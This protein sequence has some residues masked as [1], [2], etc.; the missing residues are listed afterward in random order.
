MPKKFELKE[1]STAHLEAHFNA[2]KAL[3]LVYEEKSTHWLMRANDCDE[4]ITR[5]QTEITRRG[6]KVEPVR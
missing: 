6:L 2:T 4:E 1:L 3:K 5:V